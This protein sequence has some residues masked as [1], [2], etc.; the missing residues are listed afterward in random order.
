MGD[1]LSTV[2]DKNEFNIECRLETNNDGKFAGLIPKCFDTPAQGRD[3]ALSFAEKLVQKLGRGFCSKKFELVKPGVPKG[4]TDLGVHC[5]THNSTWNGADLTP[6]QV[7]A[8]E[9]CNDSF[10]LT[11]NLKDFKVLVGSPSND[12][13][14]GVIGYVGLLLTPESLQ[15]YNKATRVYDGIQRKENIPHIT[16]CGWTI[17]GYASTSQ[18]RK[19]FGLIT[20]NGE[21]Y[22]DGLDHYGKKNFPEQKIKHQGFNAGKRKNESDPTTTTPDAKR[23]R[24]GNASA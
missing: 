9:N 2:A 19:A 7:K 3:L 1:S 12:E 5:S 18:A 20:A 17:K 11:V 8:I 16:V 14:T 22:E 21:L 4:A 10:T 6:T 24:K 23:C 13:H 15:E